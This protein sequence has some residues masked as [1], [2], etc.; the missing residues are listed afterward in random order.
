MKWVLIGVLIIVIMI[1]AYSVSEQYKD[2]FDFYSNLKSFLNQFKINL[3]FK[4]DKITEF[5]NKIECKRQFK[6]FIEAYKEYLNSDT[7]NL[8]K[9]KVLDEGEKAQLTSIVKDIG[10]HDARNELNQ[11]EGFLLE[12]EEKLIKAKEDKEKICPMIIKLSLLFAIGLAI[13]L[14]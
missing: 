4:Q 6:I 9:I 2:K 5:L 10:K 8:E 1:I 13:L 11:L 3:A 14:I 7:L 12:I